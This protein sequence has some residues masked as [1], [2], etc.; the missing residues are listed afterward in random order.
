M[1]RPSAR[2]V[3]AATSPGLMPANC[4]ISHVGLV[5][6]SEFCR[7]TRR[8]GWRSFHALEQCLK[9]HESGQA[10]C[11][12]THLV[13]H[14]AIQMA[15]TDPTCASEYRYCDCFSVAFESSQLEVIPEAETWSVVAKAYSRHSRRHSS[16]ETDIRSL[17]RCCLR[18]VN[19]QPR[20]RQPR[21][22]PGSKQ[23]VRFLVGRKRTSK[24]FSI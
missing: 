4:L 24:P 17:T 6:V 10:L 2:P 23:L 8:V 16:P 20:S 9:P 11:R 19:R 22:L 1:L 14:E 3:I 12:N 18:P 5:E 15:R 13:A 21:R 7:S